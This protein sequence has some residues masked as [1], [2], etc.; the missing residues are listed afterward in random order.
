MCFF[1]CHSYILAL[2]QQFF[3]FSLAILTPARYNILMA[4]LIGYWST[5]FTANVSFW[6]DLR[7]GVYEPVLFTRSVRK[8]C[9][10]AEGELRDAIGSDQMGSNETGRVG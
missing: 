4:C 9:D 5:F 2:P 7:N 10:G 3:F 8:A 1:L 6:H